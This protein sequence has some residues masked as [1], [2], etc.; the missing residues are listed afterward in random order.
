[1]AEH[2]GFYNRGYLPHFDGANHVQMITFRLADSLPKSV[3]QRLH[4]EA[5]ML[6][7][8]ERRRYFNREVETLL[9]AGYGACWLRDNR[10]ASIV[11]ES[12]EHFNGER[13]VL[14]AYVIMPNHVHCIIQQLPGFTLA[15]ILKTWKSFSARKANEVLGRSGVFWQRDY[16]DTLISD[17]QHLCNAAAYIHYNPVKAGLV[18]SMKDWRY[19][20]YRKIH[21]I[22][23]SRSIDRRS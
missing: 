15:Q 5:A 3:L 19:S 7:E 9:D 18:N 21:R 11:L 2:L 23:E 10:I 1:M 8:S 22:D 17:E 12:L 14:L 20:S 6:P 13:Y 4:D 16:F